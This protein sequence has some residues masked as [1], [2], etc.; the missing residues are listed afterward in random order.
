MR[1]GFLHIGP[2][3]HGVRRYGQ[4]LASEAAGRRDLSVLQRSVELSGDRAN[5]HELLRAAAL[6]LRGADVVHI[7]ISLFNQ[8]LWG[9][10]WRQLSNL[11]PFVDACG[12]PVVVTLHD[13]LSEY[14]DDACIGT[15]LRCL[16]RR[17]CASTRRALP[18]RHGAATGLCSDFLR[19]E[20]RSGCGV[21]EF[22]D[23]DSVVATLRWLSRRAARF[24]VFRYGVTCKARQ[25]VGRDDIYVI[26]HFV[27]HRRV[28]HTRRQAKN[29]LGLSANRVI[30]LLGHIIENKGHRLVLNSMRH[31]P[32]DT[33]IVFAGGVP[34]G[35]QKDA[36]LKQLVRAA[37]E[38]GLD[39]RLIITGY[40]P[41]P[42][43]DVYLAATDLALCPF[44]THSASGSLSTWIAVNQRILAS[45]ISL[46]SDYN[47]AV[48]NSIN[49]FE[50]YTPEA[51][52]E[53]ICRLL[54]QTCEEEQQ[55]EEGLELLRQKYAISNVFD[56][57]LA[58]YKASVG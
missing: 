22:D 18:G 9:G 15:A 36:F 16:A 54:P 44:K 3:G 45:D 28:R 27:E 34:P 1:L 14:L 50:P 56:I 35:Y 42:E 10:G 19:S 4:M 55:P 43:L 39:G 29:A 12:R 24:F 25:L 6:H 21:W 8:S 52:A 13:M 53:S 2:P 49:L 47:G 37:R 5:D 57:H 33:K 23:Y 30:T 31:L 17:L 26:P 38:D 41:D 40:L 46:V 51:L 7:Q 32:P 11:R 58:H 48:P 20:V